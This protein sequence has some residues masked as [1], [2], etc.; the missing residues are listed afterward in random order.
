MTRIGYRMKAYTRRDIAEI[1]GLDY[2]VV[3]NWSTGKP[4]SI[5]P[6]LRSPARKGA[7]NFFS[8]YDLEKFIAAKKL[9]DKGYT[10]STVGRKLGLV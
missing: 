2:A 1:T 7:T 3:K 9:R 8:K 5:R 4:L 10:V 6:S